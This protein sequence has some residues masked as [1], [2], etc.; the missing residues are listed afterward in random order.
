MNTKGNGVVEGMGCLIALSLIVVFIFGIVK[1]GKDDHTLRE[2]TR[3]ELRIK[4]TLPISDF[5]SDFVGTLPNG[6]K[7]FRT[8]IPTQRS[9]DSGIDFYNHTI[10]WTENG[11]EITVNGVVPDGK[12]ERPDVQVLIK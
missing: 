5:K 7:L 2:K 8:S 12:Y 3:A 10:Y 1:A 6:K 9:V 4:A 11:D